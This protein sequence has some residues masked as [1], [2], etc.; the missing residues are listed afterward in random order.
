[1][2][3]IFTNFVS[4]KEL[5]DLYNLCAVYV[6]ASWHEGFGLP[7]LEAMACGIPVIA[8]RCGG[9]DSIIKDGE[10][11]YLVEVG[12]ASGFA[13][14]LAMVCMD[15]DLNQKMGLNAIAHVNEYFSETVVRKK[16]NEVWD[17]LLSP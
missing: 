12:D 1:M 4:D 9:P 16:F 8:T 5:V 13:D 6:F 17:G 14:K 10:N 15:M 2:E 11:G 3:L 7:V